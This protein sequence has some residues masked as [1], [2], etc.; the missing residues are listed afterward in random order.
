M[1]Q[2][3]SLRVH[4]VKCIDETNG[5]WAERFGNDEIWL[6]GYTISSTGDTQP[7]APSEVYA[8]FDDGDVKVFEPPRVFH[9]FTPALVGFSFSLH[10]PVILLLLTFS[11]GMNGD[12]IPLP[13]SRLKF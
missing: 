7:I 12:P 5:A 10:S 2:Q 9:T 1:S 8:G 6:G 3:I 11:A 4:S 13:R